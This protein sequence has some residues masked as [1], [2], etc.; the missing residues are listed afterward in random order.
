MNR[1]AIRP[2]PKLFLAVLFLL[3]LCGCV[4][5]QDKPVAASTYELPP[6]P[7]AVKPGET[8]HFAVSGDSRNCGDVVMPAIAQSASL[9]DA[10]FYWHLGD[11]RAIYDFDQ[12]MQQQ[13][14]IKG[15]TLTI[16][17]YENNAWKNFREQQAAKFG[18]IPFFLGIGNHETI[19][20]LESRTD[21]IKT[22]NDYLDSPQLRDQRAADHAKN[23]KLG[24]AVQPYYH[25]KMDG[26][27]FIYLDNASGQGAVKEPKE[28]DAAQLEW[29]E[30]LLARDAADKSIKTVIV[31]MHAALPNSFSA[32][33]SMNEWNE[34]LATGTRVYRDL[35]RLQNISRKK[36]YVLASHSHFYMED[37]FNTKYWQTT[38]GVLPGWIVGTAGAE[39]YAL[40]EPRSKISKTNVYGFLLGTVNPPNQPLGTVRFEFKELQEKDVHSET[41]QTYGQDLVH[42]CFEKNSRATEEG[43]GH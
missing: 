4:C 11:L 23:P 1:K 2:S 30:W 39:R 41:V 24:T 5:S 21:F 19:E 16:L 31:G 8:W 35:L 25:W 13:Y 26:L 18:A 22:F 32:G 14:R 42:W 40:P 27:D 36:V 9:E 33:H 7:P 10:K 3:L 28:I 29:F 6:A 43:T 17:E 15:Q 38:G 20:K 37:I 34:G 12:D